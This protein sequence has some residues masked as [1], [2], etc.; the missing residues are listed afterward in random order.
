[1]AES[2]LTTF[3]RYSDF[4]VMVGVMAI[5]AMLILPM[6]PMLLDI[7]LVLNITL[8]LLVLLVTMYTLQP[9]EFSIFP[10]LLLIATLFRLA[11]NVSATRLILLYGHEG[12][13]AA[14]N[15]IEAFGGFVVG[16][17]YFVG[18]VVF[19]IIVVIQFVVV[20]SG[21]QRVAEVA[22]RF[23]LDAMP[24]KQM[25]IDADLNSGLITDD[26]ARQRRHDVEREADFYGA[27]DGASKFVRGDAIAAI[28]ILVADILGGFGVGLLKHG[29]SLADTL[30]RYTLLTIGDGLVTQVP[31]II[32]ATAT[33]IIVTRAASESNLGMD[34]AKQL[35][36]QPRA[37]Y[38][39]SVMM[40]G[41][42]VVP[43]MPTV[44][45]LILAVISGGAGYA[46]TRAS[47]QAEE[48]GEAEPVED[49]KR[50]PEDMAPLLQVDTL[51]LELGY[52]LVPLVDEAQGG[53]LL[54][55]ITMIRRNNA[56]ELGLIV[57]PIRIRDNLQLPA[58][59]YVIKVKGVELARGEMMIGHFLAMKATNGGEGNELE[60]IDTKE[61][62]FGLP[63]KWV[64]DEMRERAEATG[65]TVVDISSVIATHMAE[66]IKAQA[67][68]ILTR[69]NVQSLIDN[70]KSKSPAVVEELVPTLMSLGDLQ[71]VLQ[72]LLK[73]RVSIRDMETILES[74][75]DRARGTKDLSALTEHVRGALARQISRQYVGDDKVL[76]V[77]TL[78]PD[79]EQVIE[80][81]VVTD[82]KGTSINLE[83]RQVQRIYRSVSSGV[84]KMIKENQQPLVLCSAGVRGFFK[85]IIEKVLPNLVVLSYNEVMPQIE[86]RSAGTI[87]IGDE[88]GT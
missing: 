15:V 7:M 36:A 68:E 60:G 88:S 35:L 58:N 42:A 83:P 11:L 2:P 8:S 24:G 72:E 22:A 10:S 82:E 65:Y 69:Q 86:V 46:V 32:M 59:V 64:T 20:T 41:F 27:M 47:R 74:L 75:A 33:G 30:Q 26:Q 13:D 45:F 14:G 85:R 87:G 48:V 51:E 81:A 17:N 56:M 5:I 21:A 53:D 66:V 76:N 54:E 39:A 73:E 40:I 6:P 1:M 55:R 71:K 61:P 38:I 44:P 79:L 63:A 34:L 49:A 31:S 77:L 25:A 80:K 19:I 4:L 57:P 84:E 67:Y 37:L 28:I 50:A 23:T 78:A 62:S 12:G 18:L 43:G 29:M 52:S 9:L 16:G 3:A 70:V